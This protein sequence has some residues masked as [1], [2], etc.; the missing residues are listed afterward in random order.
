MSLRLPKPWLQS[1]PAAPSTP[2]N[3]LSSGEIFYTGIR[4]YWNGSGSWEELS[5]MPNSSVEEVENSWGHL[6]KVTTAK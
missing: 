2:A 3:P 1:W 5:N 4:F 6:M